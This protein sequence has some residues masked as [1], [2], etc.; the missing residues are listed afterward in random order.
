MKHTRAQTL[1]KNTLG[2]NH[3]AP[4]SQQILNWPL[5]LSNF[6][7][8]YLTRWRLVV[9]GQRANLLYTPPTKPASISIPLTN[10]TSEI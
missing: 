7:G 10:P 9:Q 2:A 3:I 5:I 8:S 1:T 6:E 4:H